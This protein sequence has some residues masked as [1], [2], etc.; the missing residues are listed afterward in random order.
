MRGEIYDVGLVDGNGKNQ[1]Y[2]AF[3]YSHDLE[4]K[5]REDDN[6]ADPIPAIKRQLIEFLQRTTE[7][8]KDTV[9]T[10]T[11]AKNLWPPQDDEDPEAYQK[12]QNARVTELERYGSDD[13][14]RKTGGAGKLKGFVRRTRQGDQY[15]P[16]Q[17]YL[18]DYHRDKNADQGADQGASA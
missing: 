10:G 15:D 7:S 3:R 18:P 2:P 17:W 4:K 11:I 12:R 6:A 5:T 16:K 8:E 13:K 9:N 1:T 14:R